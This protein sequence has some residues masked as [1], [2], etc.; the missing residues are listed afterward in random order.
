MTKYKFLPFI[1]LLIIAISG[2]FLNY[3]YSH[4]QGG[5]SNPADIAWMLTATALVL[6]MTPGLS[7]F[8]GGMV[9]SKNIISTMLQSVIAMSVISV[10]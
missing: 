2:A 1:V 5:P 3:N 8:Y 4:I 10:V 6:L 9:S 7:Y